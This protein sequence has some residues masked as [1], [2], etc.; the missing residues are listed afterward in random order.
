MA[1]RPA[2]KRGGRPARV[3]EDVVRMGEQGRI[4]L[5]RS[6]RY[7]LGLAAGDELS[8]VEKD[9][10]IFLRPLRDRRVLLRQI[11]QR[12]SELGVRLEDLLRERRVEAARERSRRG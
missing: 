8:L 7:R 6:L 11:R 12:W 5:P 9:E 10:G 4:V 1:R 3:R 2:S